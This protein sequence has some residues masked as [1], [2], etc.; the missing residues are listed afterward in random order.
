MV[1]P[2][3]IPEPVTVSPTSR[4]AVEARLVTVLPDAVVL[5]SATPWLLHQTADRVR[6]GRDAAGLPGRGN[7]H[8]VAEGQG[9]L[10][11]TRGGDHM[12]QNEVLV[13]GVHAGDRGSGGDA[14]PGDQVS[15]DQLAQL[16]RGQ[17]RDDAGCA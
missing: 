3:T 6:A 11:R 5:P 17:A 14:G 2:A 15:D 10:V 7:N 13:L 8:G 12:R 1:V 9:D 16:R 4:E